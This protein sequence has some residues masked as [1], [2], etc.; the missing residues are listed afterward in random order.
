ME[1]NISTEYKAETNQGKLRREIEKVLQLI[2]EKS[3]YHR[4]VDS[5]YSTVN[6]REHRPLN[7]K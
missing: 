3:F 6:N 5:I 7:R 1:T 4:K 2:L